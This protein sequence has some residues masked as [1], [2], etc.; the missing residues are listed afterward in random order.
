MTIN[1]F[2]FGLNDCKVAPWN[3]VESYGTA[4]DV[5][6]VQM[7]GFE[8]QTESGELEGDDITTDVHAKIQSANV[9][10]RFAFKDLA[11][12]AVLTGVS[13]VESPYNESMK[14]GRDNMPYFAVCGRA[15]ATSGGGDTQVFVP[16]CKLLDA[17]SLG[18]EKG[19]YVTPEIAGKAVYEGSTYGIGK[20][21]NNATA[22]NVT[23]PPTGATS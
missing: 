2:K 10:F 8:L 1:A 14:F 9:R 3:G 17:F 19:S 11:V 22:Q 23:I 21:I 16:K 15:D 13:H 6:S 4:V 12:L 7:F 20:I 18:F 5:E